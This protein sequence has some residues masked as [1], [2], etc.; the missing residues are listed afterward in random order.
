VRGTWNFTVIPEMLL[1]DVIVQDFDAL[2]IPG[3]F[4]DTGYYADVYSDEFL[5]IIRS[6]HSLGKPIATVCVGALP[7]ARSGVLSGRTATTY[8]IDD[9]PRLQQLRS[10]GIDAVKQNI[11]IN[12]NVITSCGPSTALDVAFT[13]LR[14][15]TSQENYRRVKYAMGFKVS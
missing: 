4:E 10:F 9:S 3:G 6:F 5:D 7:V 2:A 13:L 1:K 15:L 14:K 12:G 11:V 8:H